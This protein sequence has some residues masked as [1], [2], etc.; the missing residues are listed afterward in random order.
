ML[1]REGDIKMVFH[2]GII[3]GICQVAVCLDV[4]LVPITPMVNLSLVSGVFPF[5]KHHM[6]C[7][8]SKS[9]RYQKMT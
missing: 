1:G 6:S 8:Y 3:F 7:L 9:H 2:D 5:V 4:L